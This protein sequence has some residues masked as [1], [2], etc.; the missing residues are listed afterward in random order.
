MQD[1]STNRPQTYP[2]LAQY[3][4][5]EYSAQATPAPATPACHLEANPIQHACEPAQPTSFNAI[6]DAYAR[7]LD[8]W[9]GLE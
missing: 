2:R 7:D 3:D 5:D 8:R 9:D 1:Q 4:A 6:L